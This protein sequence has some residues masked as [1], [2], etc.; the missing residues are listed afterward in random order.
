M[1]EGRYAGRALAARL[2]GRSAPGPFRYR[3]KGSLATIGR[4][5]AVADV[6]GLHLSGFF[7][8]LTWL[9]VHIFYLIG[10]E[11]RIVV[12]IRW[13]YSYF[14]RGRGNRLITGATGTV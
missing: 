14:S 10:F 11:N 3:D 6:R 1:Q 4:D 7:A 5:K 8:W 9:T 13:A 2:A 12:L